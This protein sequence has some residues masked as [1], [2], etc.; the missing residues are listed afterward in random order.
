MDHS[1][2]TP[3]LLAPTD[4]F[5]RHLKKTDIH[6]PRF[7]ASLICKVLLYGRFISGMYKLMITPGSA[8]RAHYWEARLMLELQQTG[9]VLLLNKWWNQLERQQNTVTTPYF[10]QGFDST[11]C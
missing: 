10:G 6:L 5:Q 2:R 1:T 4:V 3:P 7:T 8:K 11:S 9:L